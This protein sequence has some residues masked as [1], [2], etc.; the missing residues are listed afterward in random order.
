MQ[1]WA[2]YLD[3]LRDGAEVV[4]IHRKKSGASQ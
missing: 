2:N 1:L 4:P 3:T